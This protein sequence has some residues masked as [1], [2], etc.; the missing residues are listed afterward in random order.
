MSSAHAAPLPRERPSG[1]PP[2]PPVEWLIRRRNR[3]VA[4]GVGALVALLAVAWEMVGRG[5]P[6]PARLATGVAYPGLGAEPTD[7][8]LRDAPPQAFA[9]LA[10]SQLAVISIAGSDS[11]AVTIPD[12]LAVL[13]G[14]P[15][16][17]EGF[18]LPLDPGATTLD[19]VIVPDM[20]R[21]WF[22]E[23]PDPR[24]SIYARGAFGPVPAEYDRPVR[25]EGVLDVGEVTSGRS[26]HSAVR[27]RAVRVEVL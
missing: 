15:V 23:A 8:A 13:S 24:R 27:L 16:R 6:P 4:A 12:S 18:M 3:R 17:V 14:R 19:F 20:S 7:E 5:A 26:F 9:D 11:P 10:W 22:C 1:P 21:C 2:F 25:V